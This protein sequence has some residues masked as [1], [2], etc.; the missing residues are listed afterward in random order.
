MGNVI[1]FE[2]RK[3]RKK[4]FNQNKKKSKTA[5]EK[6]TKECPA[7]LKPQKNGSSINMD[8]A[9]MEPEEKIGYWKKIDSLSDL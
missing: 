9:D 1:S 4:K 8:Y 6:A 2:K 7:V 5:T 3:K